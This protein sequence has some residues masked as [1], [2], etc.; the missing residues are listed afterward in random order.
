ME[1]VGNMGQ[2]KLG[3]CEGFPEARKEILNDEGLELLRFFGQIQ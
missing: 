2:F 1:R 3:W